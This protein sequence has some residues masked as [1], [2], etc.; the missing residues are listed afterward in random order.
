MTIE[1]LTGKQ[2]GILVRPISDSEL[3][4]LM[5][6]FSQA[7]DQQIE[8]HRGEIMQ[9]LKPISQTVS[10]QPA[11]LDP[12]RVTRVQEMIRR[13]A[14][15]RYPYEKDPI[16][17][18]NKGA[19]RPLMH[20]ERPFIISPSHVLEGQNGQRFISVRLYGNTNL[21]ELKI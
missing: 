18:L 9:P 4:D 1:S 17:A 12:E 19:L 14:K 5:Q 20:G 8:N 15:E 10:E 13:K 2:D 21:A 11:L 16:E 6:D 3:K 7:A